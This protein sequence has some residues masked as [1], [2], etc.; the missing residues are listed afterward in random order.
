MAVNLYEM[1]VRVFTIE[2]YLW[3]DIL[4]NGEKF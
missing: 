4:K 2:F 3:M 1:A